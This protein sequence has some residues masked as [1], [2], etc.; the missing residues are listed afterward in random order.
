M[1]TSIRVVAAT[2][3][4]AVAAAV[5]MKTHAGELGQPAN[6][7]VLNIQYTNKMLFG[8]L[9]SLFPPEWGAVV[10]GVTYL[11]ICWGLLYFLH[12]KK[13]YLKV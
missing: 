10:L 13:V 9:A 1:K 6:Q 5:A 3:A 7:S 11:A 8:R 12:R 4:F 2:A